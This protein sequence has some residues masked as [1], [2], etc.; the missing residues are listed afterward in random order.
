[1]GDEV[2]IYSDGGA[3]PNPGWGGWAAVLCS[4]TREKEISGG[5][6]NTTNNRMELTAAL[7]AL[8]ALKRPCTIQFHTDSQY[9]RKGITEWIGKWQANGWKRGTNKSQSVENVDLWQPLWEESQRHTI[10][11]HWVKGH[12][13][14]EM[15]ERVDQLATA[16]RIAITPTQTIPDDQLLIFAR[17]SYLGK[18]DVG[19]WAVVTVLPTGEVVEASGRARQT[20]NNRMELTAV[21]EGIKLV[22]EGTAA[23]I[24]TV[25]DY[26]FQGATEWLQGWRK[27]NWQKKEGEPVANAD[28]WQAI[29]RAMRQSRI[30]WV[31]AK[32]QAVPHKALER[33]AHLANTAAQTP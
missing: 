18:Q 24:F 6:P 31:N 4:G 32:N 2:T 16:A 20:T 29:D 30:Q 7:E 5:V 25:S 8:R 21:L 22:P 12:A 11:W 33:A 27:R 1:M 9:L 19:G 13:G 28:L 14:N 10:E 26:V 23:H 17:A 15:N 3:D